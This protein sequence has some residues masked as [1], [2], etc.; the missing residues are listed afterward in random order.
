MNYYS[1]LAAF[2][3]SGSFAFAQTLETQ[4]EA[5]PTA[6]SN[7]TFDIYY[8]ADD[9]MM[10]R[11]P[12]TEQA[13]VVRGYIESRMREYG[14]RPMGEAGYFQEFPVP[15]FVEVG[16]A[17][18]LKLG[19]KTLQ[20]HVQFYPVA[21]SSNGEAKGKSVYVGYGIVAPELNY[22]SYEGLDVE[23]KVAVLN[24]SAPDGVHPHSAY[25]AYHGLQER[26]QLAGDRGAV[27]V[28]L[29]N[30][31]ETASDTQ[32]RFKVLR[33]S[34]LPVA[35]VR[36]TVVASKLMEKSQRV[37]LVVEQNETNVPGY[38]VVGFIDNGAKQ[39]VVLGAHYDHIG[40]GEENSLY[41]GPAAIHN[42]ADDNGSGTVLLLEL[43]RELAMERKSAQYNYIIQFY[44]A[45]ELG[46]I[47]SKYWTEHPT[48]PLEDIHFM[49]NY[50]MVGK[51]RE[52]RMQLSGTGTAEEWDAILDSTAQELDIK[53]DPNGIGPSDQ[54]S[55]YLKNIPVLHFFTGTHPD[56]HKP[57][58][59]PEGIMI[60]GMVSQLAFT[61]RI[62]AEAARYPELHFQKTKSEEQQSA[63]R[64]SVTLGVIPDYLFQ[65]PG[66]RIDGAT[67]G[68]PGAVAGMKAGDIILE[69]GPVKIEDIY[70][71]MRALASFK[72]GDQTVAKV[73]RGD[74][75]LELT[76]EF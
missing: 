21:Y 47:G 23:G 48:F 42:G 75:I 62:L 53:R 72:K 18:Q 52:N 22:N 35:F 51:L 2:F 73:K 57:T 66:L 29:I 20:S 12:G 11:F 34:G 56:Y 24:V 50:D 1:T 7:M 26:I 6:V 71:Y 37:E 49:I 17:T 65:G 3:I 44:S 40:M 69:L 32:E 38:N 68:K 45:E 16:A 9:A 76:L 63:P 10:G 31:E 15:R 70:A 55:F 64:F 39:N 19:K 14:L 27:A 58:D 28:L 74:E 33:E 46:L 8:I 59:D 30:P 61:H 25:L 5:P 60:E 67:E 54:T 13:D 43:M 4:T 41:K 36:D